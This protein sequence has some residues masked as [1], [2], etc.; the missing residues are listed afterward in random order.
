[1]HINIKPKQVITCIL[2]IFTL[3][4]V[5]YMMTHPEKTF[6]ASMSGLHLWWTFV[7]P[8]MLPIWMIGHF[9]FNLCEVSVFPHFMKQIKHYALK[10]R[11][12]FIWV[13]LHVICIHHIAGV[14]KIQQLRKAQILSQSE[15]E[16]WIANSYVCNPIWI[17]TVVGICFLQNLRLGWFLGVTHYLSVF[18]T[19][20]IILIYTKISNKFVTSN[21][22][23]QEKF[24][25]LYLSEHERLPLDIGSYLKEAMISTLHML[26]TSAGYILSFS[27]LVQM[28]APLNWLSIQV[29]SGILDIHIATYSFSQTDDSSLVFMLAAMSACLAWGGISHHIQIKAEFSPIQIRYLIFFVTRILHA[30]IAYVLTLS[31]WRPWYTIFPN[32][33]YVLNTWNPFIPN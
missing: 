24:D 19:L 23:E 17:M 14:Q 4:I 28:I 6:Q 5:A 18:I 21:K 9:C 1:M 26:F 12:L 16:H 15:A 22:M 10:K 29:L 3:S 2:A 32:T 31:L 20:F 30:I 13:W 33:L 27:V 25:A 8:V 11:L 7:F